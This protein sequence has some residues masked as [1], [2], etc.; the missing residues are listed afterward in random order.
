MKIKIAGIVRNSVVDG[1]GIRFVVF[2]QGC[3]L[4]CPDCHNPNTHDPNGGKWKE[5]AEIAEEISKDPLLCGVTFSGGEPFAQA[6]AF[7]ELAGLLSK[8][9][10]QGDFAGFKNPRIVCYS[11]Y[12]FEELYKN[13]EK[14]ALLSEIDVLIDGRFKREEKINLSDKTTRFRGSGNQ[15]AI[16]CKESVKRGETVEVVF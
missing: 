12:T 15:R 7:A 9:A 10:K 13:P 2:A 6:Q 16:D 4:K 1:P 8:K 5:V 14:R 3:P 11:G